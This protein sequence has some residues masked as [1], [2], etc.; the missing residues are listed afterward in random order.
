[1]VPPQRYRP[2][3][4]APKWL[5]RSRSSSFGGGCHGAPRCYQ[6]GLRAP[7]RLPTVSER[8]LLGVLWYSSTLPAEIT[9]AEMAA[10]GL[11]VV[12][13]EVTTAHLEATSHEITCVNGCSR[14]RSGSVGCVPGCSSLLPDEITCAEMAAYG[15]GMV[16]LEGALVLPS[17]TSRDYARQSGRVDLG[18]V[19]SWC[20]C[21]GGL[22][23][24]ATLAPHRWSLVSQWHQSCSA[25]G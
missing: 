18:V 16:A 4:R 2:R 25:P 17:G 7:Q 15:L 9:C 1:V 12:A 21:T 23:R 10:Y 19:S 13:L 20:H 22:D 11:G 24:G 8:W 14:S 5:H 6:P 3:I